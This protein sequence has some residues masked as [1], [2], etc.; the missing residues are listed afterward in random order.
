VQVRAALKF[1]KA[2]AEV[3]RQ[4]PSEHSGVTEEF[5]EHGPMH[6]SE[7]DE[8]L[9]GLPPLAWLTAQKLANAYGANVD[10]VQRYIRQLGIE[11]DLWVH[12]TRVF[13]VE[14]LLPVVEMME[15]NGYKAKA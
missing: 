10:T 1:W 15:R 14:T 4:H 11:P 9:E 8:M 12:N 3:S 5:T 13:R 2:I 6:L 7:I